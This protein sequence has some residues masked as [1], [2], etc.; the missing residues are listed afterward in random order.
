M[1]GFKFY[2][3]AGQSKVVKG[4][5]GNVIGKHKAACHAH[6]SFPGFSVRALGWE[7]DLENILLG[8]LSSGCYALIHVIFLPNIQEYIE[9]WP[10]IL[11]ENIIV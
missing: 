1:A 8:F 5:G 3:A 4:Q 11:P 6:Q 10:D 2:E 7:W 9:I